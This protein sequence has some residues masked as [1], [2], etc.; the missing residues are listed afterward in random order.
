MVQIK[1]FLPFLLIPVLS[2]CFEDEP[3]LAQLY[4]EQ[5][6]EVT[7][8]SMI[9][10][11]GYEDFN[12]FK[13]NCSAVFDSIHWYANT[14][15]LSDFLGNGNPQLL[16]V[17]DYA[18]INISCLG[19][20]NADTTVYELQ[21]N[22]CGRH[23]YIPT[24]FNYWYNSNPGWA[25]VVNTNGTPYSIH[26]EIRN[27]DGVKLF[28]TTDANER[29]NGTYNGYSVP[30]GSYLYYIE[31]TISGEAPVEYTGWLEMLG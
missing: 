27:F 21:L 17:Q 26:W 28:E 30:R 3:K 20:S 7:E 31:L 1:L 2:G 29:W 15:N 13:L 12:Y 4:A 22:Y 14:S 16:S 25:P 24:A 23:I 10:F 8:D 11:S 9:C 18:F 5:D 19:F 6:I